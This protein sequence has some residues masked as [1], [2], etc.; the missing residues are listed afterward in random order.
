MHRPNIR[1][2]RGFTIIEFMIVVAMLSLL[3]VIAI[4]N[5]L[6]RQ[7]LSKQ[8]EAKAN[9]KT[10]FSAQRAYHEEYGRYSESVHE[11]GFLPER[12]NR[13]AYYFANAITCITRQASGVID[14]PNANCI[15]VDVAEFPGALRPDPVE[16]TGITY[17][18]EGAN[19]G[20]PGLNGCTGSGCNISGLATGNIDNESMSNDTWW[21]STKDATTIHAYCGNSE[22]QSVAG[23]PYLSYDDEICDF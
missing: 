18:G 3:A 11:V 23:E 10:W 8:A 4:P 7:T 19:P 15:T 9:L 12:G 2:H 17:A 1:K 21:I 22:T 16:P 6:K 20:M 14:P 13:Y 5:F